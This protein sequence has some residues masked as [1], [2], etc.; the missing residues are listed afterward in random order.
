MQARPVT[1][2]PVVD[3]LRV[4]KTGI[5]SK[6]R[7]IVGGIQ[8]ARPGKPA[9]VQAGT[10]APDGKVVPAKSAPAAKGQTQGAAK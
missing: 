7:I 5:T 10:I 9:Q 4:I 2:G 6:D 8:R 1:L 3:G